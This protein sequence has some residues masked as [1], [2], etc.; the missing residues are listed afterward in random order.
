MD[1]LVWRRL[2]LG[3][4]WTEVGEDLRPKAKPYLLELP[5]LR[6]DLRATAKPELGGGNERQ[7]RGGVTCIR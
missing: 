5:H 7:A 4:E 6:P 2:Q 3:Q 1:G